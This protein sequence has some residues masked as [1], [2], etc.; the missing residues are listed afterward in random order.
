MVTRGCHPT[1]AKSAQMVH[2]GSALPGPPVDNGE[3]SDHVLRKLQRD[4]DLLD[5]RYNDAVD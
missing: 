2:P 1:C 5:T 4:I 3:I